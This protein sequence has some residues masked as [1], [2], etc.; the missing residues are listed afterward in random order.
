[1]LI[2]GAKLTNDII[3]NVKTDA[4]EGLEV[5]AFFVIL[6]VRAQTARSGAGKPNS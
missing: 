1:L 3:A 5:H 6:S 4:T 2:T